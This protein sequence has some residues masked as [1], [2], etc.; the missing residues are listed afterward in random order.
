MEEPTCPKDQ[1]E[2]YTHDSAEYSKGRSAGESSLSKH[3]PRNHEHYLV[4]HP[5]SS[6]K[7]DDDEEICDDLLTRSRSS[8]SSRHRSADSQLVQIFKLMNAQQVKNLA[9]QKR[10]DNEERE[11]QNKQDEELQRLHREHIEL[12]SC[13]LKEANTCIQQ[14]RN[15]KAKEDEARNID[16]K[17]EKKDEKAQ[18]IFQKLVRMPNVKIF[19]LQYRGLNEQ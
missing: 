9:E 16:A 15:E 1:F 17:A 13:Q 5:D 4:E 3:S 6:G 14:D 19:I 12:L 7:D 2:A 11:R 18:R 10:R 8:R